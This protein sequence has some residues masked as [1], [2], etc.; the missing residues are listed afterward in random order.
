MTGLFAQWQPRYAEAGIPTFPVSAKRPAVR[1]YLRAGLPASRAFAA[2][3]PEA[4]ALGFSVERAGLCVVDIDA[5]DERLLCDTIS[6]YGP[7]PIVV[8]SGSGNHQIW[9]RR[10]GEAR[11]IRP[12]KSRP[13]DILGGGFVV[14][15]PSRGA[16]G[17]YAFISGSLADLSNLPAITKAIPSL[18]NDTNFALPNLVSNTNIH[19]LPLSPSGIISS[20]IRNDSLFRE[21][22]KRA[23]SCECVADLLAIAAQHNASM[24]NPPLAASEVVAC[25]ASAWGYQL[26]GKN[27]F[28]A[29]M[30]INIPASQFDKICHDPFATALLMTLHRRHRVGET[31]VVANAMASS[32]NWPRRK[33]TGARAVLEQSGCLHV[34]R[35]F[36]KTVGPTLYKFKPSQP[37][38]GREG[39][40]GC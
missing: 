20:G 6:E 37:Q 30:S 18:A 13:I 21:C 38:R 32:L 35:P 8:R 2:K 22:M 39:R 24:M 40:G 36:S 34:V 29:E 11:A 17:D 25:A 23:R 27:R 12:D 16:R 15:P 26:D 3:F 7:S 1:H 33:L 10:N 5:P 28:G 19:P 9:Y 31:F 14:A 4:D